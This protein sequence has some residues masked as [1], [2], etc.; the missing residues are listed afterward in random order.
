LT[1]PC[2][3]TEDTPEIGDLHEIFCGIS[4][5]LQISDQPPVAIGQRAEGR[6]NPPPQR[7]WDEAADGRIAD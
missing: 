2:E 5:L 3:D 1:K 7:Q 6:F 4:A